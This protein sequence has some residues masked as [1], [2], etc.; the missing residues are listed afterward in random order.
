MIYNGIWNGTTCANSGANARVTTKAFN[1][2]GVID[3]RS[4]IAVGYTFNSNYK[5]TTEDTIYGVLFGTNDSYSGNSTGST[6]KDYLENTWFTSA[7]SSYEDKLEPSAGYC[8][9]RSIYGSNRAL[10]AENAIISTPYNTASSGVAF[11]YFGAGYRNVFTAR[12]P[13]LTCLR[14]ADLYTMNGATNGNAQLLKPTALL[15]ADEASFAGTG[16]GGSNLPGYNN[17]SFLNSG[18]TFLLLS[19]S[20]RNSDSNVYGTRIEANG[21]INGGSGLSGARGVRPVISLMHHIQVM[22]G[23]GT[24]T[25]PWT[26]SE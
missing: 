25:S 2:N 19:P 26:I 8:N 7:I 17:N 10:L 9:D 24:A 16:Y 11:Y 23:N 5:M 12:S 21:R 14:Q 1:D 3:G 6:I 20:C 18:N 15:T 4:I 13:S 22:S